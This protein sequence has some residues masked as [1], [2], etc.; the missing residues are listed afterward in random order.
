MNP[1]QLAARI[2]H[3]NLR[4][5]ATENDI[6]QTCRKAVQYHFGAVVVNPVWVV[7]AAE[8]I[9]GSAVR[10]VTVAG[11]PLGASRTETK[12]VEA[13]RSAI[14]GALEIDLVVNLG[15]LK[16]GDYAGVED[17]IGQVRRMLPIG[18]VLKVIIEAAL[19]DRR[20]QIEA[21]RTVINGGAQFVKTG[22]GFQGGATVEQVRT[23]CEAS[24]G[25]I[26][27]K[28]AGGI[29]T[30]QQCFDLLDAGAARLGC[31]ASIEIMNALV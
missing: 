13:V 6:R 20:Q 23:L 14:D 29:R 8:E 12:I 7:T 18:T 19:L 11:F 9:T 1:D 5:D 27:V 28:A 17:E 25:L 4:A 24:G 2:E 16:A 3:T 22:T 26:Q 30:P 31:S 10:L 21:V 15:R